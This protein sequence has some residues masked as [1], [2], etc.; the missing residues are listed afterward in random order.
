MTI[1]MFAT[2]I[3]SL[4]GLGRF[5]IS[6]RKTKKDR[7]EELKTEIRVFVRTY[8]FRLKVPLIRGI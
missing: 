1:N 8:A 3:N 6:G 2:I 4:V 5:M 7:I